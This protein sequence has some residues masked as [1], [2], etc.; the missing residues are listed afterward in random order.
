MQSLSKRP[1][2]S[3]KMKINWKPW[4]RTKLRDCPA[5]YPFF[6][7]E[8]HQ[9]MYCPPEYPYFN[10]HTNLC[11]NCGSQGYDITLNLVII[12]GKINHEEKVTSPSNKKLFIYYLLLFFKLSCFGIGRV[13]YWRNIPIL[14]TWSGRERFSMSFL[15]IINQSQQW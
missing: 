4:M 12:L 8:S 9:C 1:I 5:D 14:S 6:N 2:Q 13:N 11:Q 7:S 3:S 10:M 15:S